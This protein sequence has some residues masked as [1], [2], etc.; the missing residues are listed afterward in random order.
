MSDCKKTK[1]QNIKI[2]IINLNEI[3][4]SRKEPHLFNSILISLPSRF[5]SLN[6]L[7]YFLFLLVRWFFLINFLLSFSNFFL[8]NS[9]LFI[10]LKCW[11]NMQDS[12]KLNLIIK[13]SKCS[14]SLTRL[15]ISNIRKSSKLSTFSFWHFKFCNLSIFPKYLSNFLFGYVIR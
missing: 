14:H 3:Q 8:F 1:K 5:L 12:S 4:L 15:L 10:F 9:F 7:I 2:K 13:L 11:S 6:L